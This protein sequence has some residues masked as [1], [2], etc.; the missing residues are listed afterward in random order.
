MTKAISKSTSKR[1]STMGKK[2]VKA[3]SKVTAK[4]A[5]T[6]KTTTTRRSA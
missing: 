5:T 6:R 1:I 4:K 2:A 3:T